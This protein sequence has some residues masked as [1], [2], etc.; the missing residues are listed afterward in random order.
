MK[1]SNKIFLIACALGFTVLAAEKISVRAAYADRQK[2]DFEPGYEE[3]TVRPFKVVVLQSMLEPNSELRIQQSDRFAL[4]SDFN[5]WK[6]AVVEQR[7]DT[8]FINQV[9]DK[10]G[11]LADPSDQSVNNYAEIVVLCP[12]GLTAVR[13]DIGVYLIE[14]EGGNIEVAQA[15]NRKKPGYENNQCQLHVRDCQLGGLKIETGANAKVDIDE[16]CTIGDLRLVLRDSARAEVG[17]TIGNGIW[18][19][20]AAKSRVSVSG[21]N[22]SKIKN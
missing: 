19:D 8:L 6:S 7:G 14:I 11:K 3:K 17:A 1:L 9:A 15:P 16:K 4:A 2:M 20:C 5:F 12:S 18:L 22:F 13:S 21:A 10:Q